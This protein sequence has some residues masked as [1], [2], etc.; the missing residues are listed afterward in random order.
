MTN[1]DFD[2]EIFFPK[3]GP[4]AIM[5]MEDLSVHSVEILKKRLE[6]L[7]IEILR[8]EQAIIHKGDARESAENFFK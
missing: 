4:I 7:K 1:Y 8:T 2:D 3:N 5:R 6:V